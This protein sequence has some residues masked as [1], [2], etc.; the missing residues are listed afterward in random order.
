MLFTASVVQLGSVRFQLI[1][2]VV[3]SV[4]REGFR[5]GCLRASSQ[6]AAFR[7]ALVLLPFWA[8]ITTLVCAIAATSHPLDAYGDPQPGYHQALVNYW[9]ALMLEGLIEPLFI[10]GTFQMRARFEVVSEVCGRVLG[11]AC[12]AASVLLP[13]VRVS[14]CILVY[15]SVMSPR[16]SFILRVQQENTVAK[17]PHRVS[18]LF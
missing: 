3:Y 8:S 4:G 14:G 2:A 12:F 9:L 11:T 16:K 17:Y 1:L 10:L 7:S 6:A 13:Q 5:R 18:C 15:V